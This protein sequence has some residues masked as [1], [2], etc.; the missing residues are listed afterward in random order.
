VDGFLAANANL[1]LRLMNYAN[2][3]RCGCVL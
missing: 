2:A 3:A 1:D